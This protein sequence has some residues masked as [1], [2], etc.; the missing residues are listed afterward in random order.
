[1]EDEK[2]VVAMDISV[3][4]PTTKITVEREEGEEVEDEE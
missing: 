2:D 4:M 1:V 3:I